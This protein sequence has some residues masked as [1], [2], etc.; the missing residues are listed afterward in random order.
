MPVMSECTRQTSL[1]FPATGKT[2]VNLSPLNRRLLV[3]HVV[4]SKLAGSLE[5]PG[6]PTVREGRVWPLVRNVTVCASLT[7]IDQVMDSPA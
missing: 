1:K 7:A 6:Q 3:A 5:N 4:P 2:T